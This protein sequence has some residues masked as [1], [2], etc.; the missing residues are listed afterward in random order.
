MAI[1]TV[2][3]ELHTSCESDVKFG[4]QQSQWHML[5][6]VACDY[7]WA[8]YV[9]RTKYRLI[10]RRNL[11]IAWAQACLPVPSGLSVA[12]A[13][14]LSVVWYPTVETTLWQNHCSEDFLGFWD[15]RMNV[16][17]T[18]V[19]TKKVEWPLFPNCIT[20]HTANTSCLVADTKST[21]RVYLNDDQPQQNSSQAVQL[22]W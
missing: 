16:C 9:E 5:L 6:C 19:H 2:N 11:S 10:R 20:C 7:C 22:L 17:T 1:S 13:S 8:C 12:Y 18:T 4:K 3:M 21:S 15:E 14:G